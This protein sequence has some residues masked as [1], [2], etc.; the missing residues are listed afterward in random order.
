VRKK[1]PS[2]RG[3]FFHRPFVPLCTAPGSVLVP[4]LFGPAAVPAPELLASPAADG[5]LL[6]VV[7]IFFC[8]AASP[9]GLPVGPVVLPSMEPPVVVPVAA[10][11][12]EVELPPVE[13]CASANVLV[14][15]NA[16]ASAM[17][18]NFMVASS[19]VLV[20]KSNRYDR[21]VFLVLSAR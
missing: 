12:P 10:G 3:F 5:L 19:G 17:V 21:P 11:A 8:I 18:L 1:A 6:P 4:V 14:S 20:S 7:P 2:D 9:D 16:V 13:F 15:A